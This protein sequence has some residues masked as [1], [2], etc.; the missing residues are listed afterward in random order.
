MRVR[1]RESTSHQDPWMNEEIVRPG[2]RK[3]HPVFSCFSL[4]LKIKDSQPADCERARSRDI[5]D[6]LPPGK[7]REARKGQMYTLWR[8]SLI[9]FAK[10]RTTFSFSHPRPNMT[11]PNPRHF[12]SRH[13]HISLGRYWRNCIY[14]HLGFLYSSLLPFSVR[15]VWMLVQHGLAR[16]AQRLF[17][18]LPLHLLTPVSFASRASCILSPCPSPCEFSLFLDCLSCCSWWLHRLLPTF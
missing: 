13:E 2:L 15:Q 14:F 5:W 9:S 4:I 12:G 3:R 10:I 16:I 11:P 18:C 1:G 6:G 7:W 8:G 17:A